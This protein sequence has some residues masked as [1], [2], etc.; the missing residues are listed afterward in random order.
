[1]PQTELRHH[2]QVRAKGGTGKGFLARDEVTQVSGKRRKPRLP[3]DNI[4]FLR[5]FLLVVSVLFTIVIATT[6][7]LMKAG[8]NGPAADMPQK[9]RRAG[10]PSVKAEC[11]HAFQPLGPRTDLAALLQGVQGGAE[12]RE[13]GMYAELPRLFSFRVCGEG[14]LIMT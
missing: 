3:L 10:L 8:W 5:L 2:H 14:L 4:L 6:V 13:R 11:I 1:M 12:L 7:I 9:Q